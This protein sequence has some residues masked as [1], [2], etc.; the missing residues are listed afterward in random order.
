VD[1]E[2][3]RSAALIAASSA[4]PRGTSA[5]GLTEYAEQLIPWITQL[6]AVRLDVTVF[7]DGSMILHSPN[8]GQMA[9][10]LTQGV[11]AKVDILVEPKDASDLVTADA[12]AFTTDDPSGAILTPSLS[13]DGRTWTGTIIAGVTGTVNVTASDTTTTGIPAYTQQVNVVAGPTTHL[14]GTV[15]VT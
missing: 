5:P 12:I 8:G 9:T 2:V 7:L 14:V 13:A 4:V 10:T 11:N 3:V 6:P 15:T 1:S